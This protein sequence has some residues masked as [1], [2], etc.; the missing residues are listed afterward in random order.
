MT[1]GIAV[2]A[3]TKILFRKELACNPDWAWLGCWVGE[4]PGQP[5]LEA[6]R[7]KPSV[8]GHTFSEPG[9]W[10]GL[11]MWKAALKKSFLGVSRLGFFDKLFAYADGG[12]RA[13]R[14]LLREIPTF[15]RPARC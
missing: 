11:P 2:T 9:G 1:P 4:S 10:E 15:R 8:F 6:F 12:L 7:K 14:R 3:I 5:F 13:V